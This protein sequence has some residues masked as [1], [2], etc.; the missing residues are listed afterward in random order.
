ML[1]SH[2]MCTGH[3]LASTRLHQLHMCACVGSDLHVHVHIF[4]LSQP[5]G[6]ACVGSDLHV[7]VHISMYISRVHVCMYV[8]TYMH[9]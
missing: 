9:I 7:H 1:N 4:K 2:P 8:C 3:V 5:R 6:R